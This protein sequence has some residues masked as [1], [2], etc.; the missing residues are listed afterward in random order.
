MLQHL[1]IGGFEGPIYPINPRYPEILGI[2]CYPSLS[3]APGPIDAVFVALPA[4]G[5]LAVLEEAGRVG[6]GAAV[7]NAA[8]FA[9][10]GPDGVA[11]QEQMVRIVQKYG[12]ALCGPNTN[13]VMSLLGNAYLCGFVPH[14]GA[15]RG[16]VA[17]C[18]Q[19]GSLANML[20]RDIA[21]LGSAYVVSG[22]N[23]ATLST[24][25]YVEAFV[26]DQRVKV[27]LLT[28]EAVRRPAALA[29]AA[30]SAAAKGKT[31]IAM[32]VGRSEQGR[33]AVQAH[34]GALA[35]EDALYDA[36]FR[37]L[38]IV[39]VDDL[40]EMIET[41]AM[42]VAR[43]RPP[44]QQGVVPVTFSGGHAAM[45]ADMA[46]DLKLTLPVLSERNL[47]KAQGDLSRHSGIQA[48]RSM[49]GAPAGIRNASSRRS[50]SWR[51]IPARP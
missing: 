16:G 26:R 37:K 22:G 41:A 27:I 28:L 45:L 15:K 8:G 50:K 44:A 35:G 36:Y 49:P 17:I 25:E 12:M 19:S 34:T 38:G 1:R 5:V 6:V 4:D 18:T 46:Q 47:R 30:L 40:D 39:R 13:G 11:M 10:A 24:A 32:K 33:A 7:V 48:I 42:F 21:S 20:S 9:D 2:K 29:A 43:P 14:E 3:D 51:P 31:I 23:E